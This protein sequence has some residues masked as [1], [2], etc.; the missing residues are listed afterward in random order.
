M[1]R[2][3]KGELSILLT[4][5]QPNR[6]ILDLFDH[7]LLL[8][9]G[10]TMHFFGTVS[11]CMDYFTSIGFP[12]SVN[13]TPTDVFLQMT[14]SHF[15]S[16]R[17]MNF[18]GLFACS[19]YASNLHLFLSEVERKG[20]LSSLKKVIVASSGG[21]VGKN[22][23]DL[24]NSESRLLLDPFHDVP[25]SQRSKSKRNAVRP[26]V[27]PESEIETKS[28]K[29]SSY[30][31]LLHT[32]STIWNQYRVLLYRDFTIAYRD[33][34]L[35]FLQMLAS[36]GFGFFVGAVFFKLEFE[37]STLVVYIQLALSWIVMILCYTQ[38]FKIYHLTR[39]NIRFK[40]ERSNNAYSPAIAWWTELTTTAIMVNAL[41]PG[42]FIALAMMNVPQESYPF[43]VILCWMVSFVS[44]AFYSRLKRL[45]FI[46]SVNCRK[47]VLLNHQIHR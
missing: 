30:A 46:D 27:D 7:I 34:S 22:G 21:V 17:E 5:H 18:E 19:T 8:G 16:H 3:K 44:F 13:Y 20:N 14:D 12:P 1:I 39:G 40:H 9:R 41:L 31:G 33:R 47:Y 35:Y 29:A 10:G 25:L 24:E 4:I 36:I 38:V 32:L 11:E 6:R 42:V 15:G 23:L 28:E 45:F 37:V 43:F 2:Q 26:A